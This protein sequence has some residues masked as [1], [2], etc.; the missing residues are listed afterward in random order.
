MLPFNER[1]VLSAVITVLLVLVVVACSRVVSV[2]I[3][4]GNQTLAVG[5]KKQLTVT[6]VVEGNAGTGVEWA[7]DAPAVVSVTAGGLVAA[8]SPG[9]AVITATSVADRSMADAITVTVSEIVGDPSPAIRIEKSTNGVDA[10]V[11]P[12]PVLRAGDP[13]TWTYEVE[14]TGNLTLHDVVVNDDR[15]G[16]IPCPK[17]EL[18]PAERMTCSAA[19]VAVAGPYA[20]LGTVTGTTPGNG[21][22]TDADPSHYFGEGGGGAILTI[23]GQVDDPFGFGAFAV[24]L[25]GIDVATEDHR[26]ASG[27]IGATGEISIPLH[28]LTAEQVD[29]AWKQ[30]FFWCGTTYRLVTG[31]LI[32]SDSVLD[33]HAFPAR[34]AYQR[35]T[36]RP[37][38]GKLGMVLY[39]YSDGPL[40][41]ACAGD[42]LVAAPD[43]DVNIVPG[44]NVL[45]LYY[46]VDV[47]P[48][49]WHVRTGEPDFDVPWHGP[50]AF[51]D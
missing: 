7:S 19:G 17:D 27:T 37:V 49:H 3:D 33:F 30:S 36:P 23:T 48:M 44:W 50:G 46:E 40:H 35:V 29:R 32:V 10:D 39:L 41:D 4:Q 18:M 14:N 45:T 1:P 43:V 8:H 6:V 9:T 31:S 51:F 20:N 12:G 13:V 47:G 42:P 15:I 24:G 28:E 34:A 5:D 21:T 11:P 38:E 16:P 25:Y 2:A 26:V 22:V